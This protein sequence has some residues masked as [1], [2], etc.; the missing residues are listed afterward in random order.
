MDKTDK[1]D[2]EAVEHY[3]KVT[4]ERIKQIEEKAKKKL[5]GFLAEKLNRE[6]TDEE[7]AEALNSIDGKKLTDE[8]M[9]EIAEMFG[10]PFV[11]NLKQI[12]PIIEKNGE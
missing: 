9:A 6:P 12:Q 10:E 11:E 2:I 4:A 7:I 8:D 5:I 1:L 3:F